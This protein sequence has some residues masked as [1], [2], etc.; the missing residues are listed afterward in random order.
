MRPELELARGS[1]PQSD[2]SLEYMLTASHCFYSYGTSGIG[3][4]VKNGYVRDDNGTVYSGSSQTDIGQEKYDSKI[5]GATTLD[6]ALIRAAGSDV[7]FDSAWKSRPRG[8][9]G[10][11]IE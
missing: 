4:T 1:Y 2:P 10:S 7:D 6:V 9:S 3:T 5:L 8:P 11:R